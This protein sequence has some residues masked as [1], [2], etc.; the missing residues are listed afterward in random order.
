MISKLAQVF[1]HR[2][3]Q[4]FNTYRTT[5]KAPSLPSKFLQTRSYLYTTLVGRQFFVFINSW[6]HTLSEALIIPYILTFP[7]I[8]PS[9]LVSGF[10][11]ATGTQPLLT[12]TSCLQIKLPCYKTICTFKKV[13]S[14]Y[15]HIVLF[16]C[17]AVK[18]YAYL[19]KSFYRRIILYY[20]IVASFIKN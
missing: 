17:H 4:L 1:V 12:K 2:K 8:C 7:V 16:Y 18:L 5:G 11:Q 6:I 15:D 19:W 20:F 10:S 3:L 13:V 14:K 9:F